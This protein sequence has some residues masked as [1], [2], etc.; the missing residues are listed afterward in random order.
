MLIDLPQRHSRRTAAIAYLE[1]ERIVYTV[2]FQQVRVDDE[3][4]AHRLQAW[5]ADQRRRRP[6]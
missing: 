5:I 1:A 2:H 3:D 4:D 6:A